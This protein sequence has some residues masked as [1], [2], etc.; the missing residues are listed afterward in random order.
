MRAA[1]GEL[2]PPG[3]AERGPLLEGWVATLLRAYGDPETG[4]GSR[5]DG[6]FYWAP[7]EGAREV[8]FLLRRRKKLVA[9][10]VK[11]KRTL[12]S[13]DFAGLR[14]VAELPGMERRLVVFLGDRPFRTEDG[15]DA[16]PVPAFVAALEQGAV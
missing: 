8:D 11:A 5:Y 14:A 3:E 4:L 15:I 9:V 12:A 2:H 1:K 16:L 7:A 13:R 6:V 10:E